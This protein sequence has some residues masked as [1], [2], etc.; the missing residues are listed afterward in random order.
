MASAELTLII[1]SDRRFEDR[2]QH[3]FLSYENH[4]SSMDC[5]CNPRLLLHH[6]IQQEPTIQ[7]VRVYW[8]QWKRG[9]DGIRR[10]AVSN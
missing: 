10:D 3:V 9:Q 4:I 5:A 7:S 1:E 8:H 6:V 2:V